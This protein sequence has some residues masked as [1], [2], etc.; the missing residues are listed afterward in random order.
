MQGIFLTSVSEVLEGLPYGQE[1]E[2]PPVPQGIQQ[3]KK[4]H[5]RSVNLVI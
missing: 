2:F 3:K 5:L 1:Y 4:F